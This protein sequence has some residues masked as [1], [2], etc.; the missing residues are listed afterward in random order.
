MTSSGCR[1]SPW[2]TG[3]EDTDADGEFPEFVVNR[4]GTRLTEGEE[5]VRAIENLMIIHRAHPW[6]SDFEK[7]ATQPVVADVRPCFQVSYPQPRAPHCLDEE[8]RTF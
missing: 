5:N 4:S 7:L 2:T 3:A 6:K 8:W 1:W